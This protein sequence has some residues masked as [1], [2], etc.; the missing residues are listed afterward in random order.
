MT[1]VDTPVVV[2]GAGPAGLTAAMALASAGL[3]TVLVG[4]SFDRRDNR[5]TALLSGSVAALDALG[6]WVHCKSQAAPLRIMRIVDDTGRLMR[7]PEVK[8]EAMEIGL[9]AFGQNIENRHLL[10]ALH[11]RARELPSLR[12]VED[13][14]HALEPADAHVTVRLESGENIK[15]SL[16]IAA[17]GRHSLCRAAAGITVDEK[18]YPQ[19]AVTLSFQHTRAHQDTST[20]FHTASGPFT[21]V[22]L[23][24][25]RSSLVWVLDPTD[26]A[27]IAQFD[28]NALSVAVERGL[29][30]ILGK[31]NVEKGRGVFTLGTLSARQFAAN[32]IALVGEAAHV[33]PPIG[34]QGLNLGLR[35]AATIAELATDA[36]RSGGD[37]GADTVMMHYDELRRA[38]AGSRSLAV[39]LLNRSLLS[40]FLPAQ[41][42]RGAG[43]YLL[44]RIGPL[45]RAAM[46]EGTAPRVQ[47][48]LMCGQPI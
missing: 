12:I 40:D 25:N 4:Q 42:G 20:E 31:V 7:A 14:V 11:A 30:S 32:R 43:L 17:D 38:D 21:Q 48:R 1:P 3:S 33:I 15:A 27:E 44:N 34:A 9:D 35:D 16:T 41:A 46:R 37:P 39:D 36:V 23:P 8:F 28:E 47:P 10:T 13:K 19:S 26:A 29:H 5:T 18:S 6:V 2:V 22:P 24:G 45:R